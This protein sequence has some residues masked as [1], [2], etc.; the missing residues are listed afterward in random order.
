MMPDGTASG[1]TDFSMARHVTSHPA[2]DRALDT[3]LRLGSIRKCEAQQ[4]GANDQSFHNGLLRGYVWIN[5]GRQALFRPIGL[6]IQN[7]MFLKSLRSSSTAL[8][9][10][11]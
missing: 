6:T 1:G 8:R 11:P 4:G 10:G 7:L 5:L 3:S 9:G 2:D